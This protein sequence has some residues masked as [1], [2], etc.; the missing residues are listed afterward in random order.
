M[1]MSLLIGILTASGCAGISSGSHVLTLNFGNAVPLSRGVDLTA[2]GNGVE[3][4]A[5]AGTLS[6]IQYYY[7]RTAEIG[8]GA[9][10]TGGYGDRRTHA[11]HKGSVRTSTQYSSLLFM[12]RRVFLPGSESYPYVFGGLGATAFTVYQRATPGNGFV[13]ANTGSSETREWDDSSTGFSF[14]LGAGLEGMLGKSFLL[15][16]EARWQHFRID[17]DKF[18][19]SSQNMVGVMSRVGWKFGGRD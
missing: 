19:R 3:R 11:M 13:W 9:E 12:A 17:P 2:W 15:G 6:G 10:L 14:A 16:V 18:S 5:N 4:P 8:V 7:Q 1:M